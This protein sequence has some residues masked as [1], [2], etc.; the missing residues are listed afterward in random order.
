MIRLLIAFIILFTISFAEDEI[1]GKIKSTSTKISKFSKNYTSLNKKMARN[2]RAILQQKLEI[3]KQQKYLKELKSMLANKERSYKKNKK[4]LEDLVKQNDK[5]KKEQND[6]EEE[7]VFVIA[8]S[9]SLSVILEG[10]YAADEESLI[11]YEILKQMLK[12]SKE[13]A[14]KLNKTYYANS[15][16]IK[17]LNK[18]TKGLKKSITSIDSKRKKVVTTQ[19]SNK[20][21]L[22]ELEVSKS[23]YK[24]KLKKLLAKQDALKKTLAKLNIIKIDK[25]KKA[26]E[27][28]SRKIAFDNKKILLD[29]NL[30]KVKKHG[31]SYQAIKTKKYRGVKTIAPL[32]SY[33]ISKKYGTYTDPIYGIKIFNESISLK[34]KKSNAKV[35]T[36]FNGK[37]IYADKTAVLDNIV[38]VEHR[39]GLHTIYANLSKIAPNIKAGK[40]I[41]KGYSIGRVNDELIF[42]VTQKSYHINPIRLFK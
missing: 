38:I 26:K 35:K 23:T 12:A 39:D 32:D 29:K 34:P 42:E 6:I 27:E 9:V 31:S 41:K 3:Q 13:K 25:I 5:L 30:P 33:T 19:R 28:E 14:A 8:Q 10:D 11:E 4:E 37:V 36:V 16:N 7:L 22:K 15:K 24:S 1:D 18:R 21:S 20:K 17:A 2:A 40:K